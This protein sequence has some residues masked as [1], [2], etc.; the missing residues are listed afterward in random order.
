MV[1]YSVRYMVGD[2]ET[3]IA[4]RPDGVRAEGG[5]EIMGRPTRD[6]S[7]F[8]RAATCVR[9]IQVR[10]DP[11]TFGRE[12][13]C[14]RM[15]SLSQL[16]DDS[17]RPSRERKDMGLLFWKYSGRIVRTAPVILIASHRVY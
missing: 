16:L 4:G 2:P 3:A 17:K 11:F 12:Y 13:P 14:I 6:R 15:G 7:V 9:P 1:E 5:A 8:P 10:G